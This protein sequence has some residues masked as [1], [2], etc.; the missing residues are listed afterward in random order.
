MDFSDI[1]NKRYS[2]RAYRPDAVEPEKLNAV[3]EA[4]RLAP[5]AANRQPFKIIVVQTKGRQEELSS[6]YPAP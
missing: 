5:T 6:V 1:I 2:A 4:A 3:L